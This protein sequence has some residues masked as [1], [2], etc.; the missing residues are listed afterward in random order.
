MRAV[1]RYSFTQLSKCTEICCM[2]FLLFP[3]VLIFTSFAQAQQI[4]KDS[5]D[6]SIPLQGGTLSGTLFTPH[7]VRKPPVVLIIAGSGPTDR[8]GNSRLLK[9]KNNSLLQL[10]DSL[11]KYGIASLRYD[12]KGVGKSQV[13]GLREE[14]MRF[15][16]GANDALAWI[17]WLRKSGYKKIY[18]AGHSEGSLIGLV[19]AQQT[20]LKGFIS[21]AGAGRPIDQVLREQFKEG[22]GPDSLVLLANRYLDT[23]LT[24]QRI[25]KPN[26][27]LFSIFRPSVQPYIISWLRY[28]PGNL[29]QKL[30]CPV[31]IVQGNKDI[32]VQVAD[33]LLLQ[34][35]KPDAQL[36]II[37][38]MNH[39]FKLVS[40]NNRIDNAKAY[41]DPSLPIA[42]S[43]VQEFIKFIGPI[44]I[45]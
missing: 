24:G 14:D 16:D 29:L 2:Q 34:K 9:G 15:E 42:S 18:I 7:G 39:V 35:I 10:A 36:A 44:R 19:A 11:S 6:C 17:A 1:Q 31:L 20:K 43:M 40:S 32:Q 33:A 21:L 3:L 8:D 12:K 41:S 37:E 22:G 38:N 25:A 4:G 27:F 23:L 5:I 45:L 28:N 30:R 13:K 26:P